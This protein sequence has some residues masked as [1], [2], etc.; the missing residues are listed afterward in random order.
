MAI[1]IDSALLDEVKAAQKFGWVYGV[2]TNPLLLARAGEDPLDVLSSLAHLKFK[3]LFYQLV[4]PTV[5]SM[6][7]ETQAV[8]QIVGKG[9]VL[10]I[11]P[12]E[13]GFRFV[14]IYRDEFLCCVTAVYSAAQALVAKEA[15]AK[16][17]AVYV[18]RATKLMGDGLGM[19][20]E[21]AEVL[22]NSETKILAASI[23]SPEE[24]CASLSAGAH[25]LTLPFD[26]LS[27]LIEHPLSEQAVEEFDSDGVGF[28][29][30]HDDHV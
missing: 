23:K 1:Y 26:V 2:T 12:T 18:N 11:P 15:G 3:Q 7:Q 4:A 30:G 8:L 29:A 19:V 9:L 22:E 14:S 21:I 5:E 20:R 25:H 6:Y 16:Y 28:H 24:S 27:K 10:K 17:V 13:T